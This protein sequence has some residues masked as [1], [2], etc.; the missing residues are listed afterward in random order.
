MKNNELTLDKLKSRIGNNI[1]VIREFKKITQKSLYEYINK[2]QATLSRYENG[3]SSMSIDTLYDI[4][5]FLDIPLEIM[6][7]KDLSY[8]DYS[9]INQNTK[10]NITPNYK[11]YFENRMLNL[12]YLSTSQDNQVIQ[13]DFI[14]AEIVQDNYIPFLFEVKH[15]SPD[16][17][18]YE[19]RLILEAQ[20]AYF[21]FKNKNRNERG[22]IITYLY[23]QKNKD[24]PITLLGLMISISH[25]YEQR[26][27][28]QKCFI[29]SQKV[30]LEALKPFLKM[31]VQ[32]EIFVNSNFIAFLTKSSDRKIYD[33]ISDPDPV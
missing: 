26:P 8:D 29:S 15:N 27:C 13:S 33:W 11:H 19:G 20:H 16:K 18:I 7:T 32:E 14:T 9:Y 6:I 10:N 5:Q 2:S 4:C 31:E 3:Q 24:T 1:R 30:E 23:P 25:G 21:Y 12:Y 28:T 22:L 17:Q